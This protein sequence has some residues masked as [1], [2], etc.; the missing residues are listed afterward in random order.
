[1]FNA[2]SRLLSKAAACLNDWTDLLALS[3]TYSLDG[4]AAVA[5]AATARW[6]A[7]YYTLFFFLVFYSHYSV[8]ND[9]DYDLYAFS[10]SWLTSFFSVFAGWCWFV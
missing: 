8:N 5:A 3:L 10:R 4:F 1:M 7:F 9:D 6:Y 2:T